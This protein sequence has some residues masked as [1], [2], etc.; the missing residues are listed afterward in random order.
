MLRSNKNK[1]W[2]GALLLGGS[3]TWMFIKNQAI[4]VGVRDISLNGMISQS[5]IPLRVGVWILNKTF[6][7]V[8]IRSISC[9]LVSNDLVVAT[10]SQAI[11]KRI[12]SNSYI[13]QNIF[14]DINSNESLS[15]LL[16]NIQSG[17]VTSTSFRLV[18][19]VVVGEKFTVSVPIDKFFTWED[20]NQLL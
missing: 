14:V 18:G 4:R 7:T 12:P 10:I 15:T 11:N 2:F 20:I 17:D 5:I 8:L 9:Q 19:E 3:L 1:N 13:E 6:G 16:A